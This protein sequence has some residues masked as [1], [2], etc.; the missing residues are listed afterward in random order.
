MKLSTQSSAGLASL[1]KH[2]RLLSLMTAWLRIVA[3]WLFQ[4]TPASGK[5]RKSGIA[6][7]GRDKRHWWRTDWR[8]HR[9]RGR[10]RIRPALWGGFLV[11]LDEQAAGLE[12]ASPRPNKTIVPRNLMVTPVVLGFYLASK[13]RRGRAY[14][15]YGAVFN[16][17]CLRNGNIS[18]RNTF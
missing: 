7:R 1:K 5:F 10:W 3:Y 12:A 4:D 2:E 16:R 11:S 8:I 6:L 13:A 18:R 17:N 9:V 15:R 14:R